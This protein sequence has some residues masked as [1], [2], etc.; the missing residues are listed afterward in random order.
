MLWINLIQ[1]SIYLLKMPPSKKYNLFY[2]IF[3]LQIRI[4]VKQ[5]LSRVHRNFDIITEF[6]RIEHQKG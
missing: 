5:Q 3:N 6:N 2:V 4:L 1:G